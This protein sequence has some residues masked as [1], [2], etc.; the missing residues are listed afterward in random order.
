M[1]VV[2]GILFLLV[3][4]IMLMTWFSYVAPSP[5]A[6]RLMLYCCE[7]FACNGGLRFNASK[8]SSYVFL[9]CRVHPV[10]IFVVNNCLVLILS[11]ISVIFFTTTSVMLLIKLHSWLGRLIV[12]LPLFRALVLLFCLIYFSLIAFLST[13]PIFGY[14]LLLHFVI[15]R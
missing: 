2:T 5:S 4:C 1:L 3:R 9:P 11:L 7:E 13:V 8:H 14:C 6:L 15:L 10:F 12:Y